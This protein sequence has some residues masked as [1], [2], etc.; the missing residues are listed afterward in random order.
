MHGLTVRWSLAGAP[1]GV[2][3]ALA[4]YVA[5]TSHARFSGKE[6]LRF[7]TWRMRA[8]EW[9]EGC[10]VFESSAARDAFQHEFAATAAES[11]GLADRRLVAGAHRALRGRRRR[12]GRGRLPRRPD[13]RL[14]VAPAV[15]LRLSPPD[16]AL[17]AAYLDA[18][19]ELADEGNAQYLDLVHPPEPG[20]AGAD[21]TVATLVD[22]E[23]FAAFCA[24]TAAFADAATPRPAGWVTSTLLWMVDDD[25]VVG[26]ISLRHALTPWLLEVGGHIGY[27]VRPSARRRGHATRA[28]ALLLP[29]AAARGIEQVLVTCD[30]DQRGVPQG[31]RGQRRRPRGRPQRARCASGSRRPHRTT[32]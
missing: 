6:G 8:G 19:R 32:E 3:Q 9:F 1:D 23:V 10:Y 12:R 15:V 21:F 14:S 5:D 24:H 13:L 29:V 31:D 30:D 11:A 4:S 28:V 17:Q 27:A 25:E 7:K 26:R 20:Y 16:P 2:E 22:P 18:L